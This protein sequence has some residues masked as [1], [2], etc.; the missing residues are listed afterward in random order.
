VE[1]RGIEIDHA[2]AWFGS[3]A[4]RKPVFSD[5]NLLVRPGEIVGIVGPNGSGKSTLLRTL[6]GMQRDREGL[7]ALPCRAAYIDQIYSAAFFNWCSL[8][9]N[10][11]L[12]QKDPFARRGEHNKRIGALM[13]H[14]DLDI[15]LDKR[16][17]QSSGGTLQQANI[18][19]ALL[20]E[21]DCLVADEPFAALDVSV[22]RRIRASLRRFVKESNIPAIFVIHSPDEVL[23]LCDTIIVIPDKPFTS[24]ARAKLNRVESFHNHKALS[25]E[26]TSSRGNFVEAFRNLL[27]DATGDAP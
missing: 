15:D 27:G 21:P 22:S 16:P 18:L 11:V 20:T 6:V 3:G 2:S 23:E 1:H 9:T 8:R 24:A 26:E 12:S 4:D 13:R 19:R 14:L 25:G 10:L 7:F 17:N 5:F